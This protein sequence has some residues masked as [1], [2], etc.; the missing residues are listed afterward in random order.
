MT[1]DSYTPSSRRS[2]PPG[3]C[4]TIRR[5][6][7][8]PHPRAKRKRKG[9]GLRSGACGP[10]ACALRACLATRA[11]DVPLALGPE[12]QT[13]PEGCRRAAGQTGNGKKQAAVKIPAWAG[14]R[15]PWPP[16]PRKGTLRS[17]PLPCGPGGPWFNASPPAVSYN[18]G[19]VTQGSQP[20]GTPS[21]TGTN[22]PRSTWSTGAS[23]LRAD[24]P[25]RPGGLPACPNETFEHTPRRTQRA[26][27]PQ[28]GGDA[29]LGR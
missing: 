5:G 18:G 12:N 16:S 4:G 10:C 27:R 11:I 24:G 25:R 6:G 29:Q 9:T 21:R 7:Q 23:A 8:P 22:K 17:S 15:L 20:I 19:C 1:G 28:P 14:P 13:R 26:S 2:H 3:C